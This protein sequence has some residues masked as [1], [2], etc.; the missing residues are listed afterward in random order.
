MAAKRKAEPN[1]NRITRFLHVIEW[2][3]NALPHPVTLFALFAA[4]V[5]VF[6]GILAYFDV[7]VVDPRPAGAKGRADNGLIEVVSLMNAEGLRMIVLN[8]VRN[9]VEFAPL[10]TVLVAL[11]GVGVAERSGWL[12]AVIRG[13]VLKAPPK[14]VTVIIVFAGVL[15][16]TASEMGY[17]VL[18]PLAA[19]VFYSLGRHPL[20]GLAAAPEVVPLEAAQV[21]RARNQ[22][23]ACFANI[24]VPLA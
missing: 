5:V 4:S 1:S 16:N 14:L 20:A 6:S 9:F 13:M 2:L 19:V 12:T 15:S 8:L 22:K 18:V 7:A 10:G 24:E 23:F 3:G 21:F 11:L 17:V